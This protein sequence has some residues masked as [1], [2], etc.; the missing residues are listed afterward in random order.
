VG[1]VPL[2]VAAQE[3]RSEIDGGRQRCLGRSCCPSRQSSSFVW[4][5]DIYQALSNGILEE[6]VTRSQKT[7]GKAHVS[8]QKTDCCH[9]VSECAN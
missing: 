2:S 9:S 6:T 1:L 8:I 5:A 7:E 3:E 4:I